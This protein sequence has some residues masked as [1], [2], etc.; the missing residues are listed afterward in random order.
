MRRVRPVAGIQTCAVTDRWALWSDRHAVDAV[1]A[2][3]RHGFGDRLE[4]WGGGRRPENAGHDVSHRAA[5]RTDMSAAGVSWA[6]VGHTELTHVDES[7][8]HA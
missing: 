4:P 7:A 5:S 2:L 1:T 8:H 6:G 3:T